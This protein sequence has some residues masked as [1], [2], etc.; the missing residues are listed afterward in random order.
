M[1]YQSVTENAPL[2]KVRFVSRDRQR[3]IFKR[4]ESLWR[5]IPASVPLSLGRQLADTVAEQLF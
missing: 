2:R 5:N 3:C 1:G 4:L